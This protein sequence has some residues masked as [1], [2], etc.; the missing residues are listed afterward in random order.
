[1]SL[2]QPV[3]KNE[4]LLDEVAVSDQDDGNFRLWWLG[5]SGFLLQWNRSHLLMDPYLSDSL[6]RKYAGTATPHVRMTEIPVRPGALDFIDVV[7][8]SHSHTDHMDA[9]TLLPLLAANPSLRIV[10]PEAER[11]IAETKLSPAK[12]RLL[13][14][15]QGQSLD[16]CGFRISAIVSAHEAVTLDDQGRSRYLGYVI[17]FGPWTLYHSGDTVLDPAIPEALEPFC[18]DIALLPINGRSAERRV[19]G[20]LN[21]SEAAWLGR[22]VR[23]RTIIP[24]HY[25]MFSFNTA[26]IG[27]FVA[28]ATDVG[29]PYHVLRCGE[30]FESAV[31]S[32]AG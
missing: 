32:S 22:Q 27:D 31:L 9:A 28:A 23:T 19:A 14:L 25:E 1:M 4:A 29:A 8:C 2:I 13:G 21:A 7:T 24:C 20:N 16:L 6:T 26:S 15:K 11:E 12:P 10:I 3:R 30:K 17:Q 5:Q 18:I